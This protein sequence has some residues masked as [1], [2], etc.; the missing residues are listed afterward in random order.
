MFFEDYK[1]D[2]IY[3]G[4]MSEEQQKQYA[5]EDM[6]LAY[7]LVYDGETI[8]VYSDDYGQQDVMVWNG[9]EVGGGCYNINAA[10]DFC[11]YIDHSRNKL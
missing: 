5:R 8:P 10:T 2:I 6:P 11:Y 1:Y 3:L 7:L 4:D 9:H